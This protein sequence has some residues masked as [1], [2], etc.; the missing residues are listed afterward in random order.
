[1]IMR[2]KRS[3]AIICIISLV[4]TLFG[5]SNEKDI[6][7][8][9]VQKSEKAKLVLAITMN[10][11]GQ[12]REVTQFFKKRVNELSNGNLEVELFLGGQLGSEKEVLE[13]MKMGEIDLTYGVLAPELY[14]PEYNAMSIPYLFKNYEDIEDYLEG[15]IFDK[16]T[17]L[18]SSKGG[19]TPLGIHS[20]GSR[21]TTSNKKFSNVTDIKGIKLRLPEI[22]W[23]ISVWAK[24]GALPTPIAATEIVTSLQT[25]VVDAQENTLT[26]IVG[27]QMWEYQKYLINTGHVHWWQMWLMSNKTIEKLS[28]EQLD[29]VKQALKETIERNNEMVIEMNKEFIDECVGKGMEL[30]EADT[31]SLQEAALPEI[32]KILKEEL[33]ELAYKKAMEIVEKNK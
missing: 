2:F 18:S 20:S 33:N 24:L 21:W 7:A 27:R 30:V 23:W 3:L 15:E 31:M 13:Q 29:I 6:Q 5:C 22:K 4:I 10:D 9:K 14:F 32:E 26:N 25:G 17:E 12:D 16:I 19:I 11:S 28:N 1:M 8:D